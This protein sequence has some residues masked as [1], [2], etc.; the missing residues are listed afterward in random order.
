M[1]KKPKE[2]RSPRKGAK[3]G[4]RVILAGQPVMVVKSGKQEDFITVEEIIEAL[5]DVPVDHI[6]FKQ[7]PS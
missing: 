6:V 5:Y 2:V 1:D 7:I 3:L 4:D